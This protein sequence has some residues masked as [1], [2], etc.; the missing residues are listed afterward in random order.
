MA[1][2]GVI[3]PRAIVRSGA[4]SRYKWTAKGEEILAKIRLAR[5]ALERVKTA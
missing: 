2:V 4:A 1:G 3:H 5:E